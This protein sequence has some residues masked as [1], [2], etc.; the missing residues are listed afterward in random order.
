M[1]ISTGQIYEASAANYQRNYAK[2]IKTGEEVSSQVKLN[3][4]SDDPIGAARV[5][6]LAQQNAMLDQYSSNITAINNNGANA[7]TALESI[8]DA[9][10]RVRELV[11]QAGNGSY[12]DADRQSTAAEL[13]ELQKQVLGLM[14]TQ[15]ANGLY[16]FSGSDGSQP[17]YST[18]ADGSYTYHGNQTGV[19]LAVGDGLVLAANTTGY[20]A[21]EQAVNT[22]RA[23]TTLTS[24]ATDDGKVGLA[25]GT[26]SSTSAYNSGF[27][28]GEPY[29]VSFVSG[30]KL[31]ITDR[32]GTDV[33]TDAST[34]GDFKF[35]T[36][37]TQ[38]I[39]FRGVDLNLNVNLS[40]AEAASASTAEAALLGRTYTLDATPPDIAVSRSPGNASTATITQS[41]VGT[42]V[43]D[44]A[45]FNNTFPSGGATLKFTTTGYELY[46][47]PVTNGKPPIAT[48]TGFGPSINAAGINFTVA[49]TP[50]DGD[51][52]VVEANTH[53]TQNVLNTLSD[54]IAVLTTPADGNLVATQKLTNAVNSA[55]GNLTSATEQVATAISGIGAR[56]VAAS[57]QG[58][59]N[60]LLKGNNKLESDSYTQAD[61]FESAS[62]LTLQKTM[63]DAS[64][65]VFLQTSKLSLFSM[66]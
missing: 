8:R 40:Q 59:T 57:A 45:A 14:N 31:L 35:N 47:S 11:I 58:T 39:T 24:P 22:T 36:S 33:T 51:T 49:G 10:Q 20:E 12:T 50:Q 66:L 7:E 21:F 6:Q 64:Q 34:A 19:G 46:A 62:R 41:E 3:T 4:A 52:F 48:G 26:V 29:T 1:R 25:G 9:L 42:T 28:G 55:L 44:R 16:L 17:P 23:S 53:Q 32:N 2:F 15:D 37:T 27:L 54:F 30:P 65:Q 63:L 5:L 61:P 18:N 56:M 43:A 38:T 13:K 60:D